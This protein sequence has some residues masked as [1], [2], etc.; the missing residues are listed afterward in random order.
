MRGS[1]NEAQLGAIGNQS[2]SSFVLQ[3]SVMSDAHGAVVSLGGGHDLRLLRNDISRGGQEGVSGHKATQVLIQHNRIHNNNTEGFK[4]EWEG[5]GLKVVAYT[6]AVI[7]GND[8]YANHGP[9]LWCDIACRGIT[10][11]NNRV[12]DNLAG[13]GIFFEISEGA[14]ITGNS[15]WNT[16]GNWAGIFVSS[17]SGANV[18]NNLV[19]WSRVGIAVQ[20]VERADRPATA[21]TANQVANNTLLMPRPDTIALEW[22]QYGAGRLFEPDANNRASSNR[23]WYPNDENGQPRFVWRN[24]MA[25]LAELASTPI[26]HDSR[27]LSTAERDSLLNA[28]SVPPP[29]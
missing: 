21:G 9:G 17:S 29:S 20:L 15:V 22:T 25:S 4:P 5:G 18:H 23:F 8:V 12:R 7:D 1:A 24:R 11:S 16:S 6:D 13:P 28:R 14:E 2:R 27:Y 26:G 10:F 3:D 19:A